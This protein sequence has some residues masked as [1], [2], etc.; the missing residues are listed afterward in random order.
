[1]KSTVYRS[2][3]SK[4]TTLEAL[5]CIAA[6]LVVL[7]HLQDI[8]FTRA[9][10]LPFG[11]LF[12]AGDRG[13]DLFF[14]LS[15]FIIMAGHQGD[16]GNAPRVRQFLYRRAT[17]LFPSV[18]IMT[19]MAAMIY[20]SSFGGVAKSAKLEPWD[21]VASAFLLPQSGPA[22]VNVTWTLKYEVFFYAL[23]AVLI[24]S[25]RM[26]IFLL[27]TWYA[28]AALAALGILAWHQSLF[29]YYFRPIS[30]EFG[31]GAACAWLMSCQRTRPGTAA[32]RAYTVLLILGASG[33]AGGLL[34]EAFVVP[35]GLEPIRFIVYGLSSGVIIL[36]ATTL[37][38]HHT[39]C[40][41]RPFVWLGGAS[42]AVYLVHY[43]VI[44]VAAMLLLKRPWIPTNDV[45][46]GAIALLGVACGAAFHVLVDQPIQA[47]LR[48]LAWQR[49]R[50]D[51]LTPAYSWQ[52][53]VPVQ[54]V[55]KREQ[56]W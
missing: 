2:T 12:T 27:L 38:R 26:G 3:P 37:E 23:F 52:P 54:S 51:R 16:I 10:I 36:S 34:Y 48:R 30:L 55:T 42:Y 24:A 47:W 33:F 41:P 50:P 7:Y 22:L 53:V 28:A 43:S 9:G 11:G 56:S 13:V 5:R 31:I 46:L 39:L 25:R 14:V 20:A 21:I 17:R 19:I 18:W 44:T 29:G 32:L 40:A 6:L 1:M 45:V 35:H 4:I 8:F 15:G 49:P